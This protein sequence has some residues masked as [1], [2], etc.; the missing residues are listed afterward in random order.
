MATRSA[1]A[2]PI[3]FFPPPGV[4]AHDGPHRNQPGSRATHGPGAIPT[5]I[6]QFVPAPGNIISDSPIA[7]LSTARNLMAFSSSGRATHSVA[8]AFCLLLAV[9]GVAPS[10]ARASCGHDVSSSVGRSAGK[11]LSNLELFRYSAANPFDSALGDPRRDRPCS[12]PS[13][14]RAPSVPHAPAPLPTMTVRSDPWCCTTAALRWGAPE[15][16]GM[17]AGRSTSQPRHGTSPLERPPRRLHPPI[18]S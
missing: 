16:I 1:A 17:L 3:P 6:L 7:V 9:G 8:G 14:S 15:S 4:P 13:C 11:S 2:S 12:G 10:P 18:L 5:G